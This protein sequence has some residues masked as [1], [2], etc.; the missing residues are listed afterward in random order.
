MSVAAC[1]TAALEGPYNAV[2]VPA[3]THA[4]DAK[5][6]IQRFSFG[7][8]NKQYLPQPLW[9]KILKDDPQLFVWTGDV[10]YADTKDMGKLSQI[11]A[12]QLRQLSVRRGAGMSAGKVYSA[13]RVLKLCAQRPN[14]GPELSILGR[15]RRAHF[16]VAEHANSPKPA[17][18]RT[19]SNPGD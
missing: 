4:P 6:E 10:V 19:H 13:M 7:S 1:S 9:K 12:S 8:C 16:A 18:A 14:R 2:E 15:K 11:Y 5:L 3:V 17:S